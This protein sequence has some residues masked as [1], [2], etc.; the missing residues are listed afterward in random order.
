MSKVYLEDIGPCNWREDLKVSEN[1]PKEEVNK[2]NKKFPQLRKLRF[3]GQ[4]D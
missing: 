2:F 4:W 3:P 1:L